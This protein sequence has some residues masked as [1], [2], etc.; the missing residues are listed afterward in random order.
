MMW[1]WPTWTEAIAIVLLSA[2]AL[3]P[4]FL[5]T[6]KKGAA[7][8]LGLGFAIFAIITLFVWSA[9]DSSPLI[10][11]D[12]MPVLTSPSQYFE[13]RVATIWTPLFLAA[14]FFG[15]FAISGLVRKRTKEA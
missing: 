12:G 2:F 1:D 7:Y 11:P 8:G 5:L 3:L 10:G 9:L 14:M 15:T 6:A 13:I 4:V